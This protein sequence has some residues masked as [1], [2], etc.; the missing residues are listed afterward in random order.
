MSSQDNPERTSGGLVG[1]V[2]GRVK[3]AVGAAT[4]KDELAREGR[5]QEAQADAHREARTARSEAARSQQEAQL[6]AGADRDRDRA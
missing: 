1:K 3:E 2:V 6:R 4:G 5:L